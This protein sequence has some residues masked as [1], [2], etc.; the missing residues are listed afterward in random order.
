M[1]TAFDPH[2][3]DLI[4]LGVTIANSPAPGIPGLVEFSKRDASWTS[5]GTER[6]AGDHLMA[7][8]IL[9]GTKDNYACAKESFIARS[10]ILTRIYGHRASAL[11][12][13]VPAYCALT[14]DQGIS[15]LDALNSQTDND[16]YVA[17]LLSL[18][19]IQQSLYKMG[20]PVIA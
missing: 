7:G 14:L 20:C 2:R 19:N 5:S 17:Q 12:T 9:A 3:E 4:V 11:A 8:A 13:S 15:T 10:R 18:K 6:Y 1:L 16:A